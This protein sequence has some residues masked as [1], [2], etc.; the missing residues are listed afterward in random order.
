MEGLVFLVIIAMVVRSLYRNSK[1]AQR[2]EAERRQA[3]GE[4]PMPQ[5]K[6]KPR[7]G[8]PG[9]LPEWIEMLEGKTSMEREAQPTPP[10]APAMPA[11]SFD[12]H[13]YVPQG[14]STEGCQTFQ[15]D[16]EAPHHTLQVEKRWETPTPV[17]ETR[18]PFSALEGMPEAM[19]GVVYAEILTRPQQRR[20][21]RP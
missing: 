10:P 12:P 5:P 9:S 11:P 4:A 13:A 20:R 14:V 19:K 2:K 15:R 16:C 18:S 17:T 6:S 1:E 7:H 8:F 3:R 21:L